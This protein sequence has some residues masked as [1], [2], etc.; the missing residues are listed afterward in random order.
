MS[1][2]SILDHHRQDE[3]GSLLTSEP[4]LIRR[5][6]SNELRHLSRSHQTSLYSSALGTPDDVRM[7]PAP[8]N[9]VKRSASASIPIVNTEKSLSEIELDESE[10]RAEYRDMRMYER[11]TSHRRS[12]GTPASQSSRSKQAR[13]IRPA[14]ESLLEMIQDANGRFLQGVTQSSQGS[15][16]V[17]PQTPAPTYYVRFVSPPGDRPGSL[18]E[19]IF[20]DDV[21]EEAIFELD[22]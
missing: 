21:S 6:G 18:H 10:A 8:T 12:K 4:Q 16:H 17:L 13:P 15:M 7:F 1:L 20:D 14:P 2:R 19:S 22:L 11:I 5:E 9:E 3:E